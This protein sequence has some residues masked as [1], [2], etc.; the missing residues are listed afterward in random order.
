MSRAKVDFVAKA[1]A[2]WGGNMPAWVGVLAAEAARTTLRGAAKKVG[3][4]VGLL[5]HVLSNT[6]P[7]GT[8]RIETK[9]RGA[10]MNETVT[11]PVLGEI[12][13]DRCLDEQG[14]PRMNTSSIRSKLYRACR[15][16]CPHSRINSDGGRR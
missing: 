8:D 16:G 6:Y 4:S 7:A 11:C 3:Y 12:G 2:A 5:S 1:E 14:M 10:L 15:G 9:V 13:R